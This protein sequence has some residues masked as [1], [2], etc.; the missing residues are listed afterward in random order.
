M[1]IYEF[2][3]SRK[4]IKKPEM[5]CTFF[6]DYEKATIYLF[7]D[8]NAK[9]VDGGV[10]YKGLISEEKEMQV[11][12]KAYSIMWEDLLALERGGLTVCVSKPKNILE[13]IM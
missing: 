9:E 5:S 13:K 6:K 1:T 11:L 3:Y 7:F 4:Y 12:T 8:F 10:M 2:L